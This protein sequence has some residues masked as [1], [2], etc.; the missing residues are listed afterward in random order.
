MFGKNGHQFQ[1]VNSG[2]VLF[3][4]NRLFVDGLNSWVGELIVSDSLPVLMIMIYII[5]NIYVQLYIHKIY[6]ILL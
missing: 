4:A 6:Y 2:M 5:Y 3:S 1:T